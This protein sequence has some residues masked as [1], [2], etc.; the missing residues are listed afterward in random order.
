MPSESTGFQSAL[1]HAKLKGVHWKVWF[2]SAMG[3]FLDGFDLFIIGVALPLIAHQMHVTK[4]GIGLIGA[5]A[6][7][8]AMIGAFTLG[9]FTDKLG[10]KAMYLFDLLFLSSLLGYPRCHGIPPRYSYFG[11][12]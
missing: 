1:D 4:T 3:V 6:P 5:A 8:G 11:S 7:L 12:C 2:L 10:R 9:R